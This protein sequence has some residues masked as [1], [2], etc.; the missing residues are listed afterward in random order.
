MDR[1]RVG[2]ERVAALEFAGD[3]DPLHL[4]GALVDLGDP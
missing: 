2:L 4:V 3:D 1:V